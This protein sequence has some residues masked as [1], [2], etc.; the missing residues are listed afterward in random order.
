MYLGHVVGKGVVIPELSKLRAVEAFAV[1]ETKTEVRAFLE[2][3]GYYKRFIAN[4]PPIIIRPQ[5]GFVVSHMGVH[6]FISRGGGKKYKGEGTVGGFAPSR[7]KL[8]SEVIVASHMSTAVLSIP[9]QLCWRV[10]DHSGLAP[11]P[12]LS[13]RVE[14][15]CG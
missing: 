15:G 7:A 1:P 5:Q 14:M 11:L 9:G 2:M 6:S 10:L 13:D 8:I 3:T 4:E 12:A